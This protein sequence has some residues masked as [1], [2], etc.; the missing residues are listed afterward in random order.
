MGKQS[1]GFNRAARVGP[2]CYVPIKQVIEHG[3]ASAGIE[4]FH[5]RSEID[6]VFA[7]AV[8]DLQNL[9]APITQISRDNRSLIGGDHPDGPVLHPDRIDPFGFD[10]EVRFGDTG[11]NVPGVLPIAAPH[12]FIDK[13]K[14]PSKQVRVEAATHMGLMG[15]GRIMTSPQTPIGVRENAFANTGQPSKNGN[16]ADG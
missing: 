3:P 14:P 6:F 15:Y 7:V 9:P 11:F 2:G 10:H 12:T 8:P 1:S 4:L 16:R 5:Q 13:D